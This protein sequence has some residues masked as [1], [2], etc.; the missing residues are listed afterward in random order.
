MNIGWP[1]GIYLCVTMIGLGI[2]ISDHGKPKTGKEN[3]LN[4]LISVSIGYGLL[5]WGGFFD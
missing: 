5:C 4:T 1:E 3:F 2:A